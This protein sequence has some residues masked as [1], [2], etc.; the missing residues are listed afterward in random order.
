MQ[1][2][3]PPTVAGSSVEATAAEARGQG[4]RTHTQGTA[5]ASLSQG[6]PMGLMGDMG[7]GQDTCQVDPAG[8]ALSNILLKSARLPSA[9]TEA[10]KSG[11]A[12]CLWGRKYAFS[13]REANLP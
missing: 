9:S 3:K 13:D 1:T 5:L 12:I 2:R 7:M 4:R 10:G 6:D 11:L 8:R